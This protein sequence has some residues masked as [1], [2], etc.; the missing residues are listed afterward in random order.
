MHLTS[1]D[2]CANGSVYWFEEGLAPIGGFV[3]MSSSWYYSAHA[4]PTYNTF[5]TKSAPMGALNNVLTNV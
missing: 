3:I 5:A 2:P 4:W 1:L